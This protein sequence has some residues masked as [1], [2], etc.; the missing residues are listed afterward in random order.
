MHSFGQRKQQQ[1]ERLYVCCRITEK[2]VDAMRTWINAHEK[3]VIVVGLPGA[4]T[5]T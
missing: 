5:P 1:G 2:V 4:F 3:N